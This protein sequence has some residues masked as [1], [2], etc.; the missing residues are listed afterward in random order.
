MIIINKFAIFSGSTFNTILLL[1]DTSTVLS[2]LDDYGNIGANAIYM[3]G[4]NFINAY[5]STT[6]D[7]TEML[8]TT[9]LVKV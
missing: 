6:E 9:S 4:E 3:Y 8:N 2:I 1:E 5:Q 7:I